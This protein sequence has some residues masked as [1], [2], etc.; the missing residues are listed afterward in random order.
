MGCLKLWSLI[1]ICVLVLALALAG[2]SPGRSTVDDSG[3]EAGPDL[4]PDLGLDSTPDSGGPDLF[5][6]DSGPSQCDTPLVLEPACG[7]AKCGNGQ[8]DTCEECTGGGGGGGGGGAA[9]AGSPWDPDMGPICTTFSETCDGANLGGATCASLG[10]AGGVLACGPDC[11]LDT[12]GCNGCATDSKIAKCTHPQLAAQAQ[13]GFEIATTPTRVAIAWIGGGWTPP[14]GSETSERSLNFSLFDAQLQ[15]IGSALCIGGEHP[16]AVSVARMNDDW[17]IAS[18]G[19]QGTTLYVVDGSSLVPTK[20]RLVPDTVGPT[21]VARPQGGPLLTFYEGSWS[22][23]VATLLDQNGN[24][25]WR[26]QLIDRTYAAGTSGVFTGTA[27]LVADRRSTYYSDLGGVRVVHLDLNGGVGATTTPGSTSTEHPNLSWH[28]GTARLVWVDFATD[29]KMFMAKL[30]GMG[31]RIGDP[32]ELPY[33]DSYF[34]WV[35]TVPMND[36]LLVLFAGYTGLVDHGSHLAFTTLGPAGATVAPLVT[37]TKTP[38]YARGHRLAPVGT[39]SVAAWVE[40]SDP[41]R[42]GLALLEP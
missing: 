27:F 37:L 3:V 24:E 23:L 38:N 33:G 2:C 31:Q 35:R 20:I 29:K 13:T 9:D 5:K 25:T 16:T 28:D 4:K 14:D 26:K 8:L 21:L 30:N 11:R 41:P 39:Q 17:I 34:N 1:S 7:P 12:S 19:E 10:Y 36:D 18:D 22:P 6:P 15:P 32:I 40:D 42:L